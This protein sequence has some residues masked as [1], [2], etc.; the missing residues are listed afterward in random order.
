MSLQF[1]L[2]SSGSGKSTYLYQQIIQESIADPGRFFL[3]I[4]PEQFTMSTQ[5]QLV[6]L[7]PQHGLM[8]VEILSFERLAYR[9]FDELGISTAAVLEETG[10]NL[11]VRRVASAMKEELP[12]L[13]PNMRKKGF[14]S[15]VKSLISELSQYHISTEEFEEMVTTTGMSTSFYHKGADLLK[16][17]QGFLDYIDEKYITSEQLLELLTDTVEDSLFVRDSIIVF[18]GFTG[19][20]PV[21]NQLLLRLFPL[22]SEIRC[23][24]TI[25]PR[26]ELLREP[27]EE[28]LFAM[29][30]RMALSLVKMAQI[31][32]VDVL[33][34]VVLAMDSASRYP[35]DS[36]LRHLEANL[37]R[38]DAT[39]YE[40]ATGIHLTT[41]Q[42]PKE[43]LS[44]VAATIRRLL[45]DEDHAYRYQDFAVVCANMDVYS[46]YIDDI[47][48]DY[49]I[50]LFKDEKATVQLQPAVEFVRSAIGMIT[51]RFSY[52]AMMHFF[53]C[54]LSGL[55]TEEIDALDN[56]LYESGIR[57]KN[58]WQHPFTICPRGFDAGDLVVMNQLREYFL[59]KTGG[60]IDAFSKKQ[61]DVRS[62]ATALYELMVAYDMEDAL[63]EKAKAYTEL[64]EKKA[65]EYE[66]IYSILIGIL[67]KMVAL[68]GDEMMSV[69]EFLELFESGMETARVGMIPPDADRVV[70]GDMERTRL[71]DISI[72]FLLGANEGSIPKA[73]SGS[74]MLSQSER[75]RLKE[76]NF[77]LAPTDREKSFIQRFYL[78]LTLTKPK[79]ALYVS[80]SRIGNDGDSLQ[81]SYLVSLL[82]Q[83]F[84]QLVIRDAL[85]DE[86]IWRESDSKALD[87][88]IQLM[89]RFVTR[90]EL[91]EEE[92]RT[93]D[94][95]FAIFYERDEAAMTALLDAVFYRH[96]D[97]KISAAVMQA[98]S[99]GVIQGS[100]SRLETYASC[101]YQFFLKYLLD[102]QQRKEHAF[103]AVDMGSLY[104]DALERYEITLRDVG[105][106]WQN[107]T[108]ERM[109]EILNQSIQ[110]AYEQMEKVESFDSARE[111]YIRTHMEQTLHRTVWALTQQVRKGTFTPRDFE[112]S[113]HSLGDEA[114]LHIPLENG[115]ELRLNGVID[116]VDDFTVGDKLY[117]KVIDYKSSAK[118]INPSDL[119]Y[120][121]QIQLVYYLNAVMKARSVSSTKEVLPAAVLYYHIDN[122]MIEQ[123]YNSTEDSLE[124][125]IL[126]ELRVK[127]LVNS[128]EVVLEALDKDIYNFKKSDVIPVR[129]KKDNTPYAD[130][131]DATEQEFTLLT[132]YVEKK[133]IDLG[134][135]IARGEIAARPYAKKTSTGCKYCEYHS[136]CGFDRKVDGFE[137]R[138][139]PELKREDAYDKMREEL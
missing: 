49:D 24:I 26:E 119:Y 75:M 39:A 1:I 60:F 86:R 68:V 45:R 95:L 81:K 99:Q 58:K 40:D 79:D 111:N 96:R 89:R 109:D 53:R 126:R 9:V 3:V 48:R 37:F 124:Q 15:Q 23:A 90:E 77:E 2:G 42:D 28:A 29:S 65:R 84:P 104:H 92:Q 18:D 56:Y 134:N 27:A 21:Q 103:E 139:L 13:G 137:Y 4:V 25:D 118:D 74:S 122:P 5:R 47:F 44:Y 115:M 130:G 136:I 61:S 62:F 121:L 54:G 52:D 14:V 120:G 46:P 70:F 12:T 128:D 30:N 105:E 72:L 78:Y 135:A 110:E 36:S 132:D 59:E 55:S 85:A 116:R 22:A 94:A 33:D 131:N 32:G 19:F 87:Y 107:I 83:L 117:I 125:A 57:G 38:K 20:T 106:D 67:D 11:V 102:L 41:A 7:H 88:C 31:T 35:S 108:E 113:L 76:A 69:A 123:D 91:S 127:G 98:F 97:E 50:P 17:Y 66:E 6:E 51:G 112:C 43:E 34:P 100:V 16:L 73:V 10:K 64:D 114:K 63:S 80:Y 101:G 82:Q 93:L 133:V 8:N 138:K 129:L 71:Q